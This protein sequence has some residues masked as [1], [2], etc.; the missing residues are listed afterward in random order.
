M[1]S[2]ASAWTRDDAA[3]DADA[4]QEIRDL[5]T[6]LAATIGSCPDDDRLL[7]SVLL[8]LPTRLQASAALLARVRKDGALAV[9][10][11]FGRVHLGEDVLVIG[12]DEDCPATRALG[13]AEP[14]IV[15]ATDDATA[16]STS[17]P[18]GGAPLA[19]V[20]VLSRDVPAAV[21]VV[22]FDAVADGVAD[23]LAV[24]R[25]LLAL[26]AQ[27]MWPS[28]LLAPGERHLHGLPAPEDDGLTPRRLTVLR[29]MSAGLSNRAIAD[30]IGFSESTVR[31]ET[32]AIYRA[33][34]VGDRRTAALVARTRG[35]LD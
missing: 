12:A 32:M 1:T 9:V 16:P 25:D 23:H 8:D 24:V 10:S 20:R 19:A 31:H 6:R 22:F 5:V 34:G 18:E 33:F 2:T 28:P 35:L 30:R 14:L 15:V 3:S 13:Q 17:L 4:R 11:R 26:H 21:L 27:V 7:R 29:Y